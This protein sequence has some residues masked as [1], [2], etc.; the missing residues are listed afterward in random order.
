MDQKIKGTI[1]IQNVDCRTPGVGLATIGLTDCTQSNY[2]DGGGGGGGPTTTCA[3]C[4]PGPH[5]EEHDQRC[6]D[7]FGADICMQVR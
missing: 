2:C 5:G 3:S 6:C 4:G 1:T 7:H